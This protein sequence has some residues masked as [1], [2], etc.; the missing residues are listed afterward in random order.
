MKNNTL[1]RIKID[2]KYKVRGFSILITN[3]NFPIHCLPNNEY[4]VEENL[5][6]KLKKEKIK[7]KKY[8]VKYKDL[9]FLL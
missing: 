1:I 4:I 5:L 7:F 8:E 3:N 2:K 9:G 6:T